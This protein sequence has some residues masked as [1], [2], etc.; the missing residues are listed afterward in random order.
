MQKELQK[1]QWTKTDIWLTFRPKG[2]SFKK[3]GDEYADMLKSATATSESTLVAMLSVI[4]G[5]P[6][7]EVLKQT[8]IN[9]TITASIAQKMRDI[10]NGFGKGK[11]IAAGRVGPSEVVS[12]DAQKAIKQANINYDKWK[13]SMKSSDDCDKRSKFSNNYK[14]K[15]T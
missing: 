14:K 12:I 3:P 2:K 5:E 11:A 7:F 10:Q 13:Y 15:E 8:Y 9:A 1:V 6:A 4:S